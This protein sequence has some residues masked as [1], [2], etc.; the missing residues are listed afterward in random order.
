MKFLKIW[1]CMAAVAANASI[2]VAQTDPG[3]F[4][5]RLCATTPSLIVHVKQDT[6]VMD[7][8][9]RHFAMSESEVVTYL[10]SLSVSKT[11]EDGLY[12]VY[13]APETGLLRSRVMKIKK[14]TKVW[15]DQTGEV[16]LLWHCGNP[17]TRG[18]SVPY[19][20][21]KPVAN[22]NGTSMDQLR[23]V[24]LQA[25]TSTMQANMSILGEPSIPE[26]PILP[27]TNLDIPIVTSSTNLGFLSVLPVLGLITN[28]NPPNA[29]PEPATLAILCI[30]ASGLIMRS[31]MKNSSKI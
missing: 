5:N 6:K 31:R 18:P 3:A 16:V 15:V 4:L 24:P 27:Q 2:A 22:P 12:V 28:T 19:D 10:R 8:Y 25:P 21:S 20:A 7:R 23:E 11:D 30:G 26:V 29:I 17:V 14:G 1:I 9:A 13:G